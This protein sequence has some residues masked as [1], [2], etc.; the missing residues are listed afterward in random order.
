MAHQ[1]PAGFEFCP[2]GICDPREPQPVEGKKN[3]FKCVCDPND[4]KCSCKQTETH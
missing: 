1:L 4:K 2:R 3:T